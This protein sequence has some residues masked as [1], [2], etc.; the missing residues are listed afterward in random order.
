MKSLYKLCTNLFYLYFGIYYFY[1]KVMIWYKTKQYIILN[2]Y[3]FLFLGFF[4]I[5]HLLHFLVI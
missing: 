5:I 1:V 4:S 3:I 2:C